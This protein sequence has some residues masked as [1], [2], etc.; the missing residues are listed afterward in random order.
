CHTIDYAHSMGV[1]HRDLKPA[2]IMV[3]EFG[4]VQVMDWGLAKVLPQ[5]KSTSDGRAATAGA[6]RVRLA[7][8][9]QT[10][11]HTGRVGSD[12]CETAAVRVLGTPAFMSREQGGGE[13]ERVDKRADVFGLGAMLCVIL[14]GQPPYVDDTAEAIRAMAIR[15]DLAGALFR[16]AGCGADG[17]LV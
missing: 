8:C 5:G 15:G 7:D 13:I 12:G 3:G 16:L 10:V 4:E 6:S 2:N 9:E 14:T 17:E 11:V 1:I